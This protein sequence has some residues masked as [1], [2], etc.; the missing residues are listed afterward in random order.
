MN[1][2]TCEE[3]GGRASTPPTGNDLCKALSRI[4][5]RD[6][7]LPTVADEDAELL[8]RFAHAARAIFE[9]V[10]DEN[11]DL[12]AASTNEVLR[13]TRPQPQLDQFEGTWHM[14]FHGPTDRLGQGWVAGCAAALTI[15]IGSADAGRLGVC[16]AP[17][18]DRVYVDRSKN[19]TRRFC[20]ASCQN[21]VK[22]AHHRRTRSADRLRQ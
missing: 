3:A 1:L 9:A 5:V 18:C 15:A 2:L 16:E 19:G 12:A 4:L 8:R 11:F 6:G 20:G 13:W 17:K 21:R 14:H 10:A 22:N 7:Q